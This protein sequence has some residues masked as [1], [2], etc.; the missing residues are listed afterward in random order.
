[1]ISKTILGVTAAA[2]IAAGSLAATTGTASATYYGWQGYGHGHH[3]KIC[4]PIYKKVVWKDR[5]G[6]WHRSF[7][8]VDYKCWWPKRHH[9]W[10]DWNDNWY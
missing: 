1:M 6:H 3:G 5:W 7:K 10:N 8:L 2:F 9:D 4:K